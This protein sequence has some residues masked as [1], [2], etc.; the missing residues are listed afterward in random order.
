MTAGFTL[1]EVFTHAEDHLQAGGQGEF[2]LLDQFLVGLTVILT[3]LGVTQDG[4][5]AAHGGK[6]VHAH[7]TR[8]GALLMIG[9]VLGGQ[10]HLGA[11]QDLGYAG[12]MGKRRSHDQ[13]HIGGQFLCLLNHGFGE[14]N[15]L[16]DRRVHLP[17]P[18]YDVL[19]H[20]FTII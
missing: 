11:L 5:G 10:G 3:T 7:F 6:H 20:I 13:L 1:L 17:V 15:A 19:S 14:F 4:V 8:V 2:R 16:G 18:G 12:Q 9:A